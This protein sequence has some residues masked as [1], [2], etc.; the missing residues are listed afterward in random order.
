ML[1]S[2]KDQDLLGKC[3]YQ[4]SSNKRR[5]LKQYWTVR[6]LLKE[7]ITAR[8]LKSKQKD[9]RNDEEIWSH[10]IWY[11]SYLGGKRERL[12]LQKKKRRNIL[13]WQCRKQ[14]WKT[15]TEVTAYMFRVKWNC[16]SVLCKRVVCKI[17]HCYLYKIRCVQQRRLTDTTQR[18]AVHRSSLNE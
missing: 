16:Q 7:S 5:V 2:L 4:C 10:N 14:T 17:V 9:K 11:F 18:E 13:H 3:Y 6:G 12:F 8:C 15:H 1:L